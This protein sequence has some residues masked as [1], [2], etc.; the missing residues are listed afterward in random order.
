MT[1][2]EANCHAIYVFNFNEV[3][4]KRTFMSF[5]AFYGSK[6]MLVNNYNFTKFHE[7]KI[8]L[9]NLQIFILKINA[10]SCRDPFR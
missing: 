7:I 1:F 5:Y 4:I 8:L 6:I 2:K 9:I 10:I 3:E